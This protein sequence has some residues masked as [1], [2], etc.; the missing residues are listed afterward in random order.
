M[1]VIIDPQ[2]LTR[3]QAGKGIAPPRRAVCR[4]FGCA[5]LHFV[6]ADEKHALHALGCRW[7]GGALSTSS[8]G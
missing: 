6:A 8:T 3:K 2:S 7:S 5:V 1:W 4:K